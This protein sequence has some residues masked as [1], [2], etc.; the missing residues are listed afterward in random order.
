MLAPV[1]FRVLEDTPGRI[2]WAAVATPFADVDTVTLGVAS[3]VIDAQT[4]HGVTV[5]GTETARTF[6]GSTTVLNAYFKSLGRITYTTAPDATASRRLTTT[7]SDGALTTTARTQIRVTPV[8]D[9]PTIATSATF[10]AAAGQPVVITYARL[11][12]AS[13][14]RDVDG[15]SL[16]FRIES[17]TAGRIEKWNGSRWVAV[18]VNAGQPLSPSNQPSLP[19][20]L[21]PGERIRW[22]P[23]VGATGTI[24]AFAVRVSDGGLRSLDTCQVS[25]TA[26]G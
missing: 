17:L 13:T 19:P 5:G 4:G 11:L 18:R 16:R 12:A 6:V 15:D 3:G 9:R 22:V 8:N 7:V 1:V 25:I 26:T 14:A 24:P 20:R 2:S 23:P 21:G 10:L